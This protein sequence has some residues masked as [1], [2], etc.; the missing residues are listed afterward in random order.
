MVLILPSYLVGSMP[1]GYNIRP[2]LRYQKPMLTGKVLI[3]H[4]LQSHSE[5]SRF[6]IFLLF[7]L[8]EV[9]VLIILSFYESVSTI[10]HLLQ[11]L[12]Y[13]PPLF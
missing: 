13:L 9:L 2:Q 7:Y 8:F 11:H 5:S 10:P 1:M 4:V 12:S 6:L 3:P